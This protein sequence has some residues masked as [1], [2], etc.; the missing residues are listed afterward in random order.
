MNGRE[1]AGSDFGD[2]MIELR[3]LQIQKANEPGTSG[4]RYPREMRPSTR[5]GGRD[6][7]A[8]DTNI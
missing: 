8:G 7:C 2:D 4:Q 3:N 5:E 6:D 1:D